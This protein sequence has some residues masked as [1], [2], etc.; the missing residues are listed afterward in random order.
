MFSGRQFQTAVYK[1]PHDPLKT[2]E[3]SVTF[4]KN[5]YLI[6]LKWL[7]SHIFPLGHVSFKRFNATTAARPSCRMLWARHLSG[8]VPANP[9]SSLKSSS[10]NGSCMGHVCP[11][12]VQRAQLIMASGSDALLAST[13]SNFTFTKCLL[14]LNRLPA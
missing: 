2:F 13:P 9:T 11:K 12:G 4:S 3:N 8:E 10:A 7:S 14:P 1:I 6:Y 5:G